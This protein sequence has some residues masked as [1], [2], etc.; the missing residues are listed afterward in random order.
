MGWTVRIRRA[1]LACPLA[2]CGS[3]GGEESDGRIEVSTEV[4]ED[5]PTVV[6]VRWTTPDAVVSH[7]EYGLV[8]A[9]EVILAEEP[10]PSREHE[11]V[12]LGLRA[13]TEY[14]ARVVT[15]DGTTPEFTF[16]T[17]AVDPELAR[18]TLTGSEDLGA[19]FVLASTA[20]TTW[21]PIVL[22]RAG[23]VVWWHRE[24]GGF[25]TTRA[26]LAHDGTAVYY[27]AMHDTDND[28]VE[29]A[30]GKVVRVPLDGGPVSEI[31]VPF[32]SHDFLELPD[33]SLAAI[34][35]NQ[36]DVDGE[37]V[38][39]NALVE[40]ADDG[41]SRE[42]WNAFNA[43]DP[44]TTTRVDDT[45]EDWT[46]ANALDY[47]EAEDAW[48]LSL[49][50]FGTILKID[51]PTGA[52]EWGLSGTA[53]RFT[54]ADLAGRFR[55]SHQF[56]Y[57]DGHLLVFDNGDATRPYTRIVDLAVDEPALTTS[58]AGIYE[59]DTYVYILGDVHTLEDGSRL[60]ALG[61]SGELRR[62]DADGNVLC[63]VVAD[64]GHGFGYLQPLDRFGPP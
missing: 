37:P 12:V 58:L 27:N 6:T 5:V 40:V 17:G 13:E 60:L 59:P 9:S 34:I 3:G 39:G 4:H 51:R 30:D 7:L 33:G 22:D 28:L 61:T 31:P 48:Y 29:A 56:E 49:R 14:H 18:L 43:F 64:L 24:T 46:H 19:N 52:V 10:E 1:A 20:G 47:D 62:V 53:N 15:E 2:A 32:L 21:G 26:W 11:R 50:N 36:Q 57:R 54:F 42:V 63:S 25:A 55:V 35:L 38:I 16:E 23:N 44:R 8:D 41:T 45:L